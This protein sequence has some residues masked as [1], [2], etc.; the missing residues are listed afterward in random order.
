VVNT[1][2][3]IG[4]G[5][6]TFSIES[7]SIGWVTGIKDFILYVDNDNESPAFG[8]TGGT[9]TNRAIILSCDSPG[10]CH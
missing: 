9:D 7:T 6:I 5:N 4:K 3:Y 10:V 8:A 2:S 1:T